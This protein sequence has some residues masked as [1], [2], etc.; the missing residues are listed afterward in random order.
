MTVLVPPAVLEK[1][2]AVLDLPMTADIVQELGRSDLIGIEAGDE[3]PYVMTNKLP[4]P[5]CDQTV[6]TQCDATPGER[7]LIPIVRAVVQVAP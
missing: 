3:I 4:I 2:Q 5:G 6:H 1:M 7:E